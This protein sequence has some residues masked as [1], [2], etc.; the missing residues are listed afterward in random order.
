MSAVDK[1]TNILR[2]TLQQAISQE[3]LVVDWVC[4]I[5]QIEHDTGVGLGSSISREVGIEVNGT[6][7]IQRSIR[8][9]IDV[10]SFEVSRRV[11]KSDVAGLYKVI[12]ND[13]V[14]LIGCNLDI[15]RTYSGLYLIRIVETL[16]IIEI[17]D[18]EGRDVIGGSACEVSEFAVLCDIGAGYVRRFLDMRLKA[19]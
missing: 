8:V 15:M 5:G 2:T 17:G 4:R 6:V 12:G 18:V 14:F 3:H 1:S 9:D 10:Q 13:D 7:E 11:D 16:D 19:Y